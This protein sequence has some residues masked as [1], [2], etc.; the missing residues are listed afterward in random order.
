MSNANH[1]TMQVPVVNDSRRLIAARK[2]TVEEVEK[3]VN[4][5]GWHLDSDM[6]HKQNVMRSR[7]HESQVLI[8]DGIFMYLLNV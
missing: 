3:F 5:M 7:N 8:V 2:A 4:F 1:T 6:L